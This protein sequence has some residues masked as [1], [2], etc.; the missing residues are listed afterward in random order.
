MRSRPI[1]I[2]RLCIFFTTLAF[3]FYTLL[4]T[5]DIF[6]RSY[7]TEP[8]TH[9]APSNFSVRRVGSRCHI[10]SLKLHSDHLDIQS[11]HCSAS[12]F[13]DDHSDQ[14]IAWIEHGR[15]RIRFENKSQVN[16]ITCSFL[17]IYRSDDYKSLYGKPI[18]NVKDGD[19]ITWPSLMLLCQPRGNLDITK[20]VGWS[21]KAFRTQQRYYFC[22]SYPPKKMPRA[23][24]S[25]QPA[26]NVLLL[27][28][29][30]ISRVSALSYLPKT[31][32]YLKQL[33]DAKIMEMYNV[34][35]D[36]TTANL[37]ALL[38]GLFEHELPEARKSYQIQRTAIESYNV[39]VLDG[40]PWIWKL[41]SEV[42]GYATHFIEDSPKWGTFQHR[43]VGF[44]AKSPPTQSYGRPC[45]LAAVQDEHYYDKILGCTS[46][47]FTHHVLLE[48]MKEFFSAYSDR[49]RFSLTFL[50]EL[51]HEEPAYASLLD[52]DL[53]H[54]LEQIRTDDETTGIFINTLVV[55]FADHGPRM[56][57]ARL[58]LEGKME[59]RL[60]LL[61]IILPK[62]LVALWPD[63]RSSLFTNQNRLLTLFD[64][65]ATLLDL[66]G[67]QYG[68]LPSR[69]DFPNQSPRGV[70]LFT[71]IPESRTCSEANIAPHWCACSQ[72]IN[73]ERAWTWSG[74]QW[75]ESVLSAAYSV[76]SFINLQ[77]DD[78]RRKSQNQ[79]RC[80]R[81]T[82]DEI[83]SAEKAEV[84]QE[85]VRFVR[86]LDVDGRIPQY[87]DDS[88]NGRGT[89][90]LRKGSITEALR[91]RIL[92]NQGSA[93]IEAT[94][95]KIENQDPDRYVVDEVSR[96]DV[97]EPLVWCL[98][99]HMW[100]EIRR[101]CICPKR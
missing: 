29:D 81:L 65:H 52:D 71:L 60:P 51:I 70:S 34:V 32:S 1:Q 38:T 23:V 6:A 63:A 16:H 33:E 15:I 85:V 41:Y 79:L 68:P 59:E 12:V 100:P 67:R 82:L 21:E 87:A 50:S 66:L 56:G 7:L 4:F 83:V 49:P 47:R 99:N 8:P 95:F 3:L 14:I 30:S 86:S 5:V 62:R 18:E 84:S 13:D 76:I 89:F 69:K 45:L 46:S 37:M 31:I 92:A 35:G 57:R 22:G 96:L 80:I 78:V 101:F 19:K 27:G 25:K 91:V 53:L 26:F 77:L 64:V 55:L 11:P 28:L 39:T 90:H 40:Y 93:Q 9:S 43:L 88:S 36:G 61:S 72:W 44:G 98:P 20:E 48:S 58:S 42:G 73:V 74:W 94:V 10:P 54:L 2:R 17:P 97:Y 75:P 24:Q